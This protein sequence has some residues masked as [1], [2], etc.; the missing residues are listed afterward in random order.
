MGKRESFSLVLYSEGHSNSDYVYT[1]EDTNYSV[2]EASVKRL[3]KKAVDGFNATVF[4]YGQTSSGK[5]H[6]MR[7]H[8]E[9]AGIIPLAVTDLFE[10]ISG[11]SSFSNPLLTTAT[12]KRFH[13]ESNLH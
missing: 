5:T 12:G 3:V 6:S 4:A 7:G 13:L 8:A 9:E 2:Y 10:E 11:V 1:G